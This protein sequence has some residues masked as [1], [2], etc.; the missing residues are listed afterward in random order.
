MWG[1]AQLPS[2][3]FILTSGRSRICCEN[4]V[5]FCKNAS[6]QGWQEKVERVWQGQALSRKISNNGFDV[7]CKL[8]QINPDAESSNIFN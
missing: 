6:F 8:E 3:I 7:I 5:W 4:L 1:R 2:D